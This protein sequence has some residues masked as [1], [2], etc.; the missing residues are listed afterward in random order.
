MNQL[1]YSLHFLKSITSV[2]DWEKTNV[3]YPQLETTP[4]LSMIGR[5]NVGKSSL[6]NALF[7][8]QA[9]K[10]SQTPGKTRAINLFQ[11]SFK[12]QLIDGFLFDLPGYGHASI[13]K[14]E[15]Q[16]WD[17]LLAHFFEYHPDGSTLLCMQ[18]A[19]HPFQ[20]ND[21]ETIDYLAGLKNNKILIFNKMD[22]LKSQKEKNEFNQ[23]LKKHNN[24]LLIFDQ[25]ESLSTI[26]A[27]TL[28]SLCQT[29][30]TLFSHLK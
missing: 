29:L 26:Q 16:K 5:S 21:L 12:N 2:S 9:A 30:A 18:D 4:S 3:E 10:V 20:Q 14:E 13:S 1:P 23:L 19:R 11:L 27:N 22:K 15:R 25:V 24:I 28:Q 6:I 8:L 17:E 7:G